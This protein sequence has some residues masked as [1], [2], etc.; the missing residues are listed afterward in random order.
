M[1]RCLN[2]GS[3]IY[4]NQLNCADCGDH[5]GRRFRLM[6]RD[7]VWLLVVAGLVFGWRWQ[8]SQASTNYAVKL[9]TARLVLQA[10]EKGLIERLS[11]RTVELNQAREYIANATM[12]A[13]P[14]LRKNA[15]NEA[16]LPERASR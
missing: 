16:P 11:R 6:L 1:A 12:D 5:I 8:Q 7:L 13:E 9:Q 3:H 2:C 4:R 15:P 14:T 10:E